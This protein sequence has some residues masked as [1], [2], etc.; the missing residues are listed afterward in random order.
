MSSYDFVVVGGGSAGSV[1]ASRLSE[2]PGVR[3]LLLEAGPADGSAAMSVPT[4][5]P[6]LQGSEID[7]R[8]TTVPQPGLG[9]TAIPYPRGKVLG[10]SSSINAMAF[11]RGHRSAIDAWEAAGAKAWGYDDLLP[12][13]QRSEH[14][15]GLDLHYRG[16]GGP[17][18]P[19]P[20]A[21]IHPT[22]LAFIEAVQERGYPAS[23]D[24]NG[25]DQEG[26]A[27]YDLTV[28]D[29]AR[30]SAADAYLR[31]VLDRPNLTVVT[32]ALARKLVLSGSRCTGVLYTFGGQLR[33]AEAGE[34]VLCAGAIGSPHLLMLSGI[35]P[36]GALRAHGIAANADL[37]GVGENLSEHP[38]APV[39]Y[40]A[41]Q[42]MPDAVNNRGGVLAA[43]RTDPALPAPNVHVVFMDFPYIPPGMHGP[44]NG[45]TIA[46]ALLNPDSRGSVRLASA[47]PAA[48]P[49][50][51]PGLLAD[52]RDVDAMVAGLRLTREIGGAQALAP[53]RQ[54]EALPG[55][56]VTTAVRQRDF[57][58]R[59]TGGYWH[60]VGTCRMGTGPAAVTDPQLRVHG[61]SGL[62]VA[63]ASV[64]PSIPAA[65]TN[66]TVL[67]IAERA[68]DLITG[69]GS[70][71]TE[72]R[73]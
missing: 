27:R 70:M 12:Y 72:S 10:G 59:S 43:L 37:P 51:D 36:A 6:A 23:A 21:T 39:V 33:T 20:A 14:T 60:P 1:V 9:G 71:G 3:V 49:L 7:W 2:D 67:A 34:V 44:H 26:V 42:P 8:Y 17:M 63:D 73:P 32:D 18:R 56:A 22:A 24:L 45:Y 62:R 40:S 61:I 11:L 38:L 35:G 68:A 53:W 19:K 25:A 66:A 69:Q 41:A 55:A 16:T 13:Y 58:R 5:W 47:D 4:A 65:N 28:A 46:F 57:L 64:M 29:G 54:E 50:I 31:P 48:A 30:Q 52:Q 15:E